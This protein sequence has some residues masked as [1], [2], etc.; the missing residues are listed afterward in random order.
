MN[1][2]RQITRGL[3]AVLFIYLAM[4]L[5]FPKI[6][7]HPPAPQQKPPDVD[8]ESLLEKTAEYCRKLESAVLYFVCREEISEKIDPAL[9][10]PPPPT[11]KSWSIA[12]NWTGLDSRGSITI[13]SA[14]SKIKN[15]Y[16]YDYQCVRKDGQIQEVRT[17]L[18]ENGK[19]KNQPNAALKMSVILYVNTMLG[20]VGIFRKSYQTEYDY[21]IVGSDKFER[22][23]V[24]IVDAKPKP[25]APEAKTLY[26]KAW[27]DPVTGN[28][29]KIEYSENRIGH[30]EVFE[31]RGEKYDRTPRVTQRAEFR[32]EKNGLRF[33]SKLFVEE[34]YLNKRG[35]AF[36]RSETTVVYKDF[37]FFTVEVG[38][39]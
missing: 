10:V 16:V 36:V 39:K 9:D 25:D 5:A 3:A 22:K 11:I 30:Y 12:D 6:E 4:P 7:T 24:I 35:R 29:M 28:I 37:K 13:T 33:P 14:P 32:A 1:R 34:A 21:T 38:I 31:A 18:E 20:P 17:L 19:K 23:P 8:L 15:S 27:I 2:T 26:G